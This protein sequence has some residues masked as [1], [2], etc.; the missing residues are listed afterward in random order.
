MHAQ[1][2]HSGS[3]HCFIVQRDVFSLSSVLVY[4]RYVCDSMHQFKLFFSLR[5]QTYFALQLQCDVDIFEFRCFGSTE[6]QRKGQRSQSIAC[7]ACVEDAKRGCRKELER[8]TFW[9]AQ[10]P[11]FDVECMCIRDFLV[12]DIKRFDCQHI[13]VMFADFWITI[14]HRIIKREW[15]LTLLSGTTKA[16]TFDAEGLHYGLV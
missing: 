16:Q 2:A 3:G 13:S 10:G 15:L 4:V 14:N 5:D 12:N 7:H 8:S 9:H 6:G 11:L 1:R